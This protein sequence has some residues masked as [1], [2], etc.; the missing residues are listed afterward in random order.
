MFVQHKNSDD[1]HITDK[2]QHHKT[3]PNYSDKQELS[4][5]PPLSLNRFHI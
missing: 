1:E 5:P 3:N 4:T 2:R